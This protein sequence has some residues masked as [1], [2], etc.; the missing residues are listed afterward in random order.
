MRGC[1][2]RRSVTGMDIDFLDELPKSGPSSSRPFW[3]ALDANVGKWAQW[4]GS[5][6]FSVM[7][8]AAQHSR[9]SKQYEGARRGGKGYL[10]RV[11]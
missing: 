10:R 9:D 4:P 8:L 6:K 1:V 5:D 7:A 2:T 3:D 11:L